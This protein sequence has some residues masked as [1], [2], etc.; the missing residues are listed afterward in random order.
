MRTAIALILGVCL[1]GSHS[2]ANAAEPICSPEIVK[3]GRSKVESLVST[4]RI[5]Q[6]RADLALLESTSK[7][8]EAT[9]SDATKCSEV[10]RKR[11]CDSEC[12]Y[13]RGNVFLFRAAELPYLST[14]SRTSN[15]YPALPPE[16]LLDQANKGLSIVDEALAK[17]AG[18]IA[19][20]ARDEAEAEDKPATP[21][22]RFRDYLKTVGQLTATKVGL[23]LAAGDVW[24]QQASTTRAE[25]LR[26]LVGQSLL[27]AAPSG[28]GSTD[29]GGTPT[30]KAS[31]Y[32]QNALW[33]SLDALTLVPDLDAFSTERTALG[34]LYRDT[35]LRVNSLQQGFLFL[36][37]DPNAMTGVSLPDLQRDL[38]GARARLSDQEDRVETLVRDWQQRYV[39]L[40]RAE[41]DV[42]QMTSAKAIDVE[43]SRLA[44]LQAQADKLKQPFEA[45]LS[46]V[47]IQSTIFEREHVIAESRMTLKRTIMERT[48]ELRQ[49][50]N[51]TDI[52]LLELDKERARD[53]IDELRFQVDRT[54]A[55][56]N[57]DMQ[58]SSLDNQALETQVRINGLESERQL[59]S[60]QRDQT[61][62]RIEQQQ[63][64][65]RAAQLEVDHRKQLKQN[66]L[67][68]QRVPVVE[69]ICAIDAQLAVLDGSGSGYTDPVSGHSC[70]V[71]GLGHIAT[72]AL[73]KLC[74]ERNKISTLSDAQLQGVLDCLAGDGGQATAN[75]KDIETAVTAVST[76]L[77][78][79]IDRQTTLIA[80]AQRNLTNRSLV[81]ATQQNSLQGLCKTISASAIDAGT[82]FDKLEQEQKTLDEHTLQAQYEQAIATSIGFAGSMAT[83]I[84]L[85]E[86]FFNIF[87]G[88][89]ATVSNSLAAEEYRKAKEQR[90]NV[91]TA[92][93]AFDKADRAYS[94]SQTCDGLVSEGYAL[95]AQIDS[96]ARDWHST[97]LQG[98]Q[99]D[100]QLQLEL[101]S[102]GLQQVGA[103]LQQKVV[104][105]E[106]VV[107]VVQ[108]E[109]DHA[110][111]DVSIARLR[112]ER[113]AREASLVAMF[114]DAQAVDK[115]I[116]ASEAARD[117]A[118]VEL[119]RYSIELQSQDIQFQRIESESAQYNSLRLSLAAQKSR[120]QGYAARVRELQDR[121]A[122]V[123]KL[124]E[125]VQSKIGERVVAN[126][127]E[128]KAFVGN[129][130]Q[131]ETAWQAD[132]EARFTTDMQR[133][134]E[135]L[136]MQTEING[137][138]AQ[139]VSDVLASR[140]KLLDLANAR[141]VS[142]GLVRLQWDFEKVASEL[143][144]G[145][146]EVLASKR[147]LLANINY[148]ANLYRNRYG[149]LAGF[150][151]DVRPIG[152]DRIF[153]RTSYDVDELLKNCSSSGNVS[154]PGE[155][156]NPGSL[157]WSTRG[158]AA[159]TETFSLPNTSVLVQSL[160]RNGTVRF[161]VGPPTDYDR[162]AGWVDQLGESG[163]GL[164]L[165][166]P[167]VMNIGE[168]MRLI[169]VGI[170]IVNAACTY[171]PKARFAHLGVGVDWAPLSRSSPT[172][173]QTLIALPVSHLS[174]Y[175][176]YVNDALS[177]LDDRARPFRGGTLTAA[178]LESV[179]AASPFQYP[180][181][182]YPVM[183][184]YEM[185][186]NA[187]LS[188]CLSSP[189]AELKLR[190]VF[191]GK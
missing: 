95:S 130:L 159:V 31:T 99:S 98:I 70:S 139:L 27:T 88:L 16:Q 37:V 29:P 180:L 142:D 35:Q 148:S 152:D 112:R 54:M 41:L 120:V 67:T 8:L 82:A 161:E 183:G 46:L 174:D 170:G 97:N 129:V 84:P 53:D 151:D 69:E 89:G 92:N 103:A 7:S 140:T 144:R 44:L 128:H 162:P 109:N 115:E 4:L 78:T 40:Q 117:Q 22:T 190:F 76:A 14:R 102:L 121:E 58:T 131:S 42:D 32:Y 123:R 86:N 189:S 132:V 36:N 23:L 145:A 45:Y 90:G 21:E 28:S 127:E 64:V 10:E 9:L 111:L 125:E 17:A 108:C 173:I 30:Y 186:G 191:T 47:P 156:C 163:A 165:W 85:V 5:A 71:S 59:V 93:M 50:R 100:L 154:V 110:A 33:V 39:D 3:E 75:C 149:V 24:Y 18:D 11:W 178:G 176:V 181:L 19:L 172:L 157:V 83:G 57:F 52:Q 79:N 133:W 94:L 138:N 182:G 38:L 66:A 122:A 12:M 81:I 106:G 13:Q 73:D 96:Y 146:P 60:N 2:T 63:L 80:E 116:A 55:E 143:T 113:R 101:S 74:D 166:S 34:G 153:V 1:L 134:I 104:R 124:I 15:D 119:D 188:K 118:R 158:L 150:T 169:D 87:A 141:P 135:A 185:S 48:E 175:P 25:N 137:I 168:S 177:L 107:S 65:L 26:Y 51:A 167:G 179:I 184:L 155:G 114:D 164:R 49:L 61:R 91:A 72:V 56:Y 43:V 136:K 126:W 68:S 171:E 187:G 6:Y 147:A 62:N 77:K 160:I 105:Q 20:R